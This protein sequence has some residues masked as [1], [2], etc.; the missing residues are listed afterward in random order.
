MSKQRSRRLRKKLH[1]GEFQE[2]GFAFK[3]QIKPGTREEVFIDALLDEVIEPRGLEF[4]GWVSVG[5][6]TKAV[7]GSVSEEDR[8]A[9]IA[10]LSARPEVESG[11]ASKLVDARYTDFLAESEM[12]KFTG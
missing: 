7:R 6:I 3:N 8:A 4:G 5:F 12:A 9:V 10:W 2:F 11:L 1:V